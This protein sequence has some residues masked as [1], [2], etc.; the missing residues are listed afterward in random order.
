[1]LQEYFIP[2]LKQHQ[3]LHLTVFQQDGAPPHFARDVKNFLNATFPQHWIGRGGHISWVPR[4]QDLS[5]LD[6]FL[7]GHIKST[8]PVEDIDDLCERITQRTASVTPDNL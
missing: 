6:F 5:P 2:F 3:C 4:S 1:M 7:W 8:T